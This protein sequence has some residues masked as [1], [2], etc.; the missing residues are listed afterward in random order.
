MWVFFIVYFPPL[1]N[2]KDYTAQLRRYVLKWASSSS[3]RKI[4]KLQNC[5]AIKRDCAY[6]ELV[7]TNMFLY[8][9][10]CGSTN[11]GYLARCNLLFQWATAYF[12]I[13]IWHHF[14]FFCL[15]QWA[16]IGCLFMGR[17]S[18]FP[19]NVHTTKNNEHMRSTLSVVCGT[20]FTWS[21]SIWR[22]GWTLTG[23]R[24][25]ISLSLLHAGSIL[26]VISA[27]PGWRDSDPKL[28]LSVVV[29]N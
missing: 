13:H 22:S 7:T 21:R 10:H 14:S 19:S 11:C 28:C 18:R 5:P 24:S 17:N 3:R 16:V 15:D 20:I 29:Q 12:H 9:S 8:L 26:S 6:S 27:S 2:F 23:L 1:I 4:V 25:V